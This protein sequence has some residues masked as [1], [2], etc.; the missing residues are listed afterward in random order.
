MS[1]TQE[2]W[3]N[4]E[5]AE[6]K[7]DFEIE[8]EEAA[9]KRTAKPVEAK[10]KTVEEP[11][12]LDGIETK[13]AQ[14]RIR[15]LVSQRKSRDEQIQKLMQD[16]EELQRSILTRE[17]QFTDTQ[18]VSTEVSEQQLTDKIELARNNYKE[19]YEDGDADKVLKAQESLN[20]A[21][22]D[23]Q[24]VGERKAAISNYE[25]ALE[26]RQEQ[27]RVAPQA[28]D[29]K[30]Q[31]WAAENEWF[32]QDSVR[33]AAALA[34]DAELKQMGFDTSDDDFYTEVDR[35][36]KKEFPHRYEEVEEEVSERVTTQPAQVVAGASR[37]PASSSKK[38][39]LSQEDV[40][41]ATKWNIPLEVYAAEK[42]KAD[43]ADGEY[44][45]IQ[46][47]RGG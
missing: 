45:T 16:N 21:Q 24:N 23:L 37:K 8:E 7:V 15:Q 40:R 28:P 33:T 31:S 38:V 20:Q 25:K 36:L 32:G 30:A 39:K 9:P 2:G 12:E 18:K 1:D 19:A 43:L 47:Q 46:T 22:L 44:T 17:K 3:N 6:E 11:E 10:E 29:P 5:V 14:K 27:K 13:G 42:R 4:I 34:I 41:L 35:R 26:Q